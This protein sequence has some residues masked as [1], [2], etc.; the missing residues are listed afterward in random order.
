[1][2]IAYRKGLNWKGMALIVLCCSMQTFG[3]IAYNASRYQLIIDREPFGADPLQGVPPVDLAAQQR[4]MDAAVADAA[5]QLRLCFLMESEAGEIRAGFENLKATAGVARSVI[6]HEGETFQ[7]MKLLKIDLLASKATLD[8]DGVPVIFELA[9]P[10]TAA[11]PSSIRK[12]TP[13]PKRRHFGGGFKKRPPPQPEQPKLSK[14]EQKRLYE[15]RKAQL[16]QYQMEVIRAGM[17]PLPI[18]LTKEMDDQLVAEG[19]LPPPG[20]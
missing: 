2:N 16:R 19:V 18:P 11:R 12:P 3:G 1:M 14:E 6:L 9:K 10:P 8:R 20:E 17:P 13:A 7:G 15:E 5:K 4:K